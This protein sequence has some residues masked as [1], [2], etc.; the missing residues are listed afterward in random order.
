M[1]VKS[2]EIKASKMSEGVQKRQKGIKS[3]VRRDASLFKCQIMA[4]RKTPAE[5]KEMAK[6]NYHRSKVGDWLRYSPNTPMHSKW[7]E[8]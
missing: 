6:N 3:R 8:Y 4:A 7:S 5:S 2:T 1:E